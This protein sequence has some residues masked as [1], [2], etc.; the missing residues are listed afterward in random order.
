MERKVQLAA[1][2]DNFQFAHGILAL[3]IQIVKCDKQLKRDRP[4]SGILGIN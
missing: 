3:K 4:A 2:G 1:E